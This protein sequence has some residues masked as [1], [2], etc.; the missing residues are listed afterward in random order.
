MVRKKTK[1][2]G[3]RP[4][5]QA[6]AIIEK[7]AREHKL[8]SRSEALNGLIAELQEKERLVFPTDL[9][10]EDFKGVHPETVKQ[11]TKYMQ[12]RLEYLQHFKDRPQKEYVNLTPLEELEWRY[13]F[14]D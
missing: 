5:Q 12:T 7:Y 10:P 11:L 14:G 9:N 1:P 6:L 3:Y 2:F 4:S 8:K 13:L